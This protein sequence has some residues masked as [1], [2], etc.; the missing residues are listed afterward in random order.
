MLC[1]WHLCCSM[2]HTS[3][4]EMHDDKPEPMDGDSQIKIA[5]M[6][7]LAKKYQYK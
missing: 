6:Y 3:F 1:R 7:H 4:A 2:G 5:Y